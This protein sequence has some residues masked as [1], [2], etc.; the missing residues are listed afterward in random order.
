L[1]LSHPNLVS[2]WALDGDYKDSKENN[3]GTCSA[4]TCPHNSTGLSSDAMFFDGVEDYLSISVSDSTTI[5]YWKKN[6]TDSSWYHIVNSSN[7]FYINGI[8]TTSQTIYVNKTVIGRSDSGNYL[9][10]LW[11]KSQYITHL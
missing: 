8:N 5:S 7:G 4:G 2:Y 11:T 10:V 1:N 9:M 3:D 6:S